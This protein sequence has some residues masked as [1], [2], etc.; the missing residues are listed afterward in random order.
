MS[1]DSILCQHKWLILLASRV[2]LLKKMP[3]FLKWLADVE[4]T[5]F[6]SCVFS[7]K[8]LSFV[9]KKYFQWFQCVQRKYFVYIKPSKIWCFFKFR[10]SNFDT[11]W[12]PFP[13]KKFWNK[14]RPSK[15][16]LFWAWSQ[17][18]AKKRHYTISFSL[19]CSCHSNAK[20][21]NINDSKDFGNN[22]R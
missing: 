1:S 17:K 15:K 2:F 8:K 3:K 21:D 11:Q 9:E 18:P 19:D 10:Q 4:Y 14:K 22:Q 20:W 16:I 6:H 7:M 5:F 12:M 13:Q